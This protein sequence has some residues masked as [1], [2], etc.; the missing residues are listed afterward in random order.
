LNQKLLILNIKNKIIEEQKQEMDRIMNKYNL[1][2]S[3]LEES[4]N[5]S[6]RKLQECHLVTQDN[7]QINK[8]R[9]DE[10]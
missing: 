10:Y 7:E 8:I 9:S 1:Q 2:I 5:T 4:L 6:E 3:N